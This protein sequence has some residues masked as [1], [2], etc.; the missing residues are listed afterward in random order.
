MGNNLIQSFIHFID[1][2]THLTGKLV[3][4]FSL[5]M[6][7]ITFII[8]VLRYGFNMGW[9]AMQESVLY[10]HGLVFL[11]GSAYTLKENGHVRIDVFYQKYSVKT[12]ALVDLFGTVFLLIPVCTFIFYISWDYVLVSWRIMETSSQPGGLP[13]VYISKTFLLLFSITLILQGI[14][15][16]L[17]NVLI[18]KNEK[19]DTVNNIEGVS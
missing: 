9:I 12:K 7:L 19:T 13:F 3:S 4:W 17:R 16:I 10:M 6:V 8:V 2:F 11:L 15:E 5:F 14:S 1:K 18:Y